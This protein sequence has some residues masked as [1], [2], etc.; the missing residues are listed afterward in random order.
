MH[1]PVTLPSVLSENPSD[2]KPEG[3][4]V[5]IFYICTVMA[6]NGKNIFG[7]V[8]LLL[9][10]AVQ[11]I[12]FMPHHHH[13]GSELPCFLSSHCV[14]AAHECCGGHDHDA[15]ADDCSVSQITSYEARTSANESR[16]DVPVVDLA[17]DL[18]QECPATLIA[19]IA[20]TL[21]HGW[22]DAPAPGGFFTEYVAPQIPCRAPSLFA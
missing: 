7:R 11:F 6:L 20:A 15:A 21:R 1:S 14:P 3:F 16:V 4:F 2:N 9:C 13:A 5:K 19:A 10:M 8:V 22:H 12:S 18:V 17:P